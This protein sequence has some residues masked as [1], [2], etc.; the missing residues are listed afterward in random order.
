MNVELLDYFGGDLN[1]SNVAIVS[2]SKKASNYTNEQN[3][4]LINYLVKHKHNPKTVNKVAE[5]T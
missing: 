4:K 5:K 2:Y 3:A 1:H